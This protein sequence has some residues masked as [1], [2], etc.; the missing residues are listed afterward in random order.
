M[1]RW[2]AG[3]LDNLAGLGKPQ[4]DVSLLMSGRPLRETKSESL[5]ASKFGKEWK[6]LTHLT[7]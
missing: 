6:Y 2:L 4:V 7:H 3:L 1:R 5:F